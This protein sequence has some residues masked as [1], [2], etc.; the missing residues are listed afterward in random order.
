MVFFLYGPLEFAVGTW[1]T[2]YLLEH[3]YNDRRAARLLSGFWLTF[4]AGRVLTAYLQDQNV[5]PQK[6][7]AFLIPVLGLAAAVV[8]GNLMPWA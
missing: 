1:A 5:L 4:L 6:V 7:D 3:G 8:L 2:T